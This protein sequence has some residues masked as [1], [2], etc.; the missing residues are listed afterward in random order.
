MSKMDPE[1]LKGQAGLDRRST[2]LLAVQKGDIED[3]E[4]HT[5]I[6]DP[7]MDTVRGGA[8]AFKS[9]TARLY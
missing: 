2:M 3:S 5:E 7:G 6:E 1:S 8:G 4:K 9:R